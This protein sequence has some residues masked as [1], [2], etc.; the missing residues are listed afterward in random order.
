MSPV[1]VHDYERPGWACG[2]CG[3]PWPCEQAKQRLRAQHPDPDELAQF[4]IGCWRT[5]IHDLKVFLT[6]AGSLYHRFVG[7]THDA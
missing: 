2:G 3:Q 1:R 7:W 5:A 4:M 6:P